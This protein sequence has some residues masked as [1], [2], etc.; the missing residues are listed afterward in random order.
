MMMMTMRWRE[1]ED[2]EDINYE[3]GDEVTISG[4]TMKNTPRHIVTIMGHVDHGKTS[5]LDSIRNARVADGEAGGI[6]Q[7][8]S[9]F[10]VQTANVGT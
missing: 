7:G 4:V 5:L 1:E 9:A 10:K 3:V 6:T 2:E 8:V